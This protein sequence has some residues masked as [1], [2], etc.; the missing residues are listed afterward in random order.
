LVLTPGQV[1]DSMQLAPVLDAIRVP[2]LGR[3]GRPRKRPDHLLADKGY[4]YPKCRHLLRRRG[5]PHTI[6][7]RRDQ[8]ARRAKHP[9][10]PL[11][12][13][14]SRYTR[15]NLVERCINRLKQWRGVATRYDKRAV[16]YR[17]TV[18][19]AALMIWLSD[20]SDTP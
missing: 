16:N 1:H 12:F 14:A 3:R 19:I 9:G 10:R 6:P 13:D 15:R 5:I 20:S 18:T 2:R 8:L 4:S 17:A 7:E 11:V